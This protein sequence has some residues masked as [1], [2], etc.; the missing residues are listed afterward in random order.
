IGWPGARGVSRRPTRVTP[1]RAP[2][3]RHPSQNRDLSIVVAGAT[4]S[5]LQ[6]SQDPAELLPMVG[7][8]VPCNLLQP[9][10]IGRRAIELASLPRDFG[11]NAE[12]LEMI[13]LL[14]RLQDVE[15]RRAEVLLAVGNHGTDWT[16][17]IER[18]AAH[19][20]AQTDLADMPRAE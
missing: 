4:G 17:P 7:D 2:H 13:G 19:A 15:R 8:V 5:V 14:G 1:T 3:R 20:V 16:D 9:R 18:A 6:E 11:L 10:D 12:R